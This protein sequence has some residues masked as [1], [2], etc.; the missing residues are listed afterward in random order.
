MLL[1][2][3]LI[4][5]ITI[6]LFLLFNKTLLGTQISTKANYAV[7]MDYETGNI[8]LNKFATERV[9]PAS[10]SKLMTLYILFESIAQGSIT[11]ESEFYV[12]NK[13]WRKGGSKMFVEAGSK[14]KVEDL[15]K[16]IIVQSGNDAC[17]VVAEGIAGDEETFADLM[18]EIAIEL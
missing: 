13:A 8:L 4:K 6:I 12:S 9:Y 18:N 3:K 15:L 17:I 14:V 7:I 16:G 11:L 2:Q 5:F 1:I 10:M